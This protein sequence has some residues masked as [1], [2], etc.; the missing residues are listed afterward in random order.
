[1]VHGGEFFL[2]LLQRVDMQGAPSRKNF[3]LGM[4]RDRR[5][6]RPFFAL[7]ILTQSSYF[8]LASKIS[9][10]FWIVSASSAGLSSLYRF[11]LANR[12]ARPPG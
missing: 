7:C 3:N 4:L 1:L 9:Q 8:H 12:R 5:S 10:I 11:T 6:S 2:S